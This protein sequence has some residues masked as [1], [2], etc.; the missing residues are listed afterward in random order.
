MPAERK[1][2]WKR[3]MEWLI[4]VSDHIVELIPSWQTFPDGKKLEVILDVVLSLFSD[5][6]LL[7]LSFF[8]EDGKM[9]NDIL[10]LRFHNTSSPDLNVILRLFF[11]SNAITLRFRVPCYDG[12]ADYMFITLYDMVN[13]CAKSRMENPWQA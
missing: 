6:I 8:S 2:M 9:K 11:L 4:C 12:Y 1:S 10:K 5:H 3:E 7:S 13:R